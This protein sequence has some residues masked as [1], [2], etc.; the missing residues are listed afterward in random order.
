MA[1]PKAK[2]KKITKP[3]AAGGESRKSKQAADTTGISPADVSLIGRFG[4]TI[5]QTQ[6]VRKVVAEALK[7]VR[8]LTPAVELRVVY[9]VAGAW[10]EWH[11]LGRSIRSYDQAEWPSPSPAAQTVAF[12]TGSEQYGFVSI[13]PTSEDTTWVLELMAP[14]ISAVLTLRAALLR[15]QK[16]AISEMEL[17]RETLR[18]RDAERRRITHD[19][20][21]DVGQMIATLKLKLKLLENRIAQNGF[22][23]TTIE[24]LAEARENVGQLLARVRNLSHTLYPRILDTLGFVPA[25]EELAN[26]VSGPSGIRARCSVRGT[27]RPL[28][29]PTT[30]ALYRCCQE[31]LSNAIRHSGA[32]RATIH[33]YF[34]EQEVRV[35]VEDNGCGF[36][37]RR[38]YDASGK[39][40]S[41][42]F[43]TI[44]QRMS[45]TGGSFRLGTA[46]G[47]G[48][49]VEMIVPLTTG[50][51][52]DERKD[53]TVDRG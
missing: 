52:D 37:P 39:L 48:T 41:S 51:K 22:S 46:S 13:S 20:H 33:V 14:Q 9:A 25:L 38:F 36:D 21:D 1:K 34:A 27:P 7:I 3:L 35:S 2:R 50:E 40:M 17:V 28:D 23:A 45:D 24:E 12:E 15:A 6:D 19:L 8:K 53:T 30:L 32:S 44:R 29:E 18:A 10:K 26:Q 11:A 47:Q 49:T 31:A 4:R 43:W 16:H 5:T 42:G